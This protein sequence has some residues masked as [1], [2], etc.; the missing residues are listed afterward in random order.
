[1]LLQVF[2]GSIMD[3]ITDVW[4]A[5]LLIG[6][7]LGF[8]NGLTEVG[9]LAIV[10]VFAS[11]VNHGVKIWAKIKEEKRK[12][13]KFDQEIK[14]DEEEHQLKLKKQLKK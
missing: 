10:T 8:I 3:S 4:N 13:I 11:L 5:P 2:S 6:G 1:M 12:Q 9:I 7:T 14:Q